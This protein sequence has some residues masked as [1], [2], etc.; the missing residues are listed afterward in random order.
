MILNRL[1]ETLQKNTNLKLKLGL[2]SDNSILDT[3][4]SLSLQKFSFREEKSMEDL[5]KAAESLSTLKNVR[6]IHL[7]P[8]TFAGG[9][10]H[11]HRFCG[12]TSY[13]DG[14]THPYYSETGPAIP[15]EDGRHYH[16]YRTI[17]QYADG[18]IHRM[19]GCTSVD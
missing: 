11:V 16:K 5:N 17:A 9:V 2:L 3:V 13:M 19:Y 12:D 6:I 18:H 4:D 8:F 1:I 15:T 10:P 7:P 14:H